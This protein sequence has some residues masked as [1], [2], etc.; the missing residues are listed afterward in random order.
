MK[1][2]LEQLVDTRLSS[3]RITIRSNS[4]N[5]AVFTLFQFA[6]VRNY[7][8]VPGFRYDARTYPIFNFMDYP[9]LENFVLLSSCL[10]LPC[11]CLVLKTSSSDLS[12]TSFTA[13][14]R[15]EILQLAASYS[16]IINLTSLENSIHRH[17]LFL[18]LCLVRILCNQALVSDSLIF[19]FS[20]NAITHLHELDE[21]ESEP[22][23]HYKKSSLLLSSSLCAIVESV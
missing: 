16:T 23:F 5:L 12:K 2:S 10:E 22:N 21:K 20:S 13:S 7:P 3:E 17:I 15:T 18:L 9:C 6:S 11:D 8:V 19:R 1:T 4:F 14:E